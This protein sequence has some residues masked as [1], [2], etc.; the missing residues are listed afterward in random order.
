MIV[1]GLFILLI[2]KLLRYSNY[3]KGKALVVR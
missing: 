3:V 2:E 1:G